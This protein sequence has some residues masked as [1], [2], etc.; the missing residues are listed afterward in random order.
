M[1]AKSKG[2]ADKFGTDYQLVTDLKKDVVMKV[3]ATPFFSKFKQQ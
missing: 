2:S 3:L 1:E